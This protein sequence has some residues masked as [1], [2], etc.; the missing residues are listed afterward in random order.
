MEKNEKNSQK[1]SIK[2]KGILVECV[3]DEHKRKTEFA[4]FDKDVSYKDKYKYDGCD[5]Y[6]PNPNSDTVSK[7]LVLLP[8]KVGSYES[9]EALLEEIQSFIHEYV[10]IDPEFEKISAYYVMFTWVYDKFNEVPYLRVIG[11]YGSGKTRYLTTVGSLCYKPMIMAGATTTSPI[12][13]MLDEISGT[14]VLDE[15]DF[16]K[17]D[18]TTDIVKILN[19]GYTKGFPVLRAEGKGVYDVRTFDVFGPKIIATREMFRDQALESRCLVGYMGNSAIRKD[20]PRTLNDNYYKKL[21]ELRNKLLAFRFKTFKSPIDLDNNVIEDIHPRLNQIAIPLM[22]VIP[23]E[24][25]RNT[26]IS[27]IKKY[28]QELL[29]NRGSSWEA[30]VLQAISLFEKEGISDVTVGQITEKINFEI[31]DSSDV[32]LTAKKVGW[33]IKSLLHLKTERRMGGYT[34]DIR[35]N[36]KDLDYKYLR[37]GIGKEEGEISENLGNSTDE[38]MNVMNNMNIRN[39]KVSENIPDT[40]NPFKN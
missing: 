34:L 4:V 37:Y 28:H 7:K 40:D 20:I 3:Y 35:R 12:F 25:A 24:D 26:I 19:S 38:S 5:I 18:L 10:D 9:E 16:A 11:D 1:V 30:E 2:D 14:L 6:P 22:S 8:S 27:F 17:S 32:D 39:S 36:K 33:I 29:D 21:L 15:A 31:N 13:R 23:G